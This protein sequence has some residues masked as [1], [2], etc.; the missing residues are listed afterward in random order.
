MA[1]TRVRV[2]D[3]I[4]LWVDASLQEAREAWRSALL[5]SRMLEV[6]RN[7]GGVVA[8]NPLQVLYLEEPPD[9]VQDS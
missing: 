7:N 3:G 2:S 1:R 6:G 8:V 5:G 9:E 4:E